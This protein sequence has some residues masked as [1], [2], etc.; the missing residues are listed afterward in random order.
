M[1]KLHIWSIL[2]C[3]HTHTHICTDTHAHTYTHIHICTDTHTHAYTHTNA[4]THAY[5]H[6]RTHTHTHAHTYAQ[7]QREISQRYIIWE[8]VKGSFGL[9]KHLP[10]PRWLDPSSS[11]ECEQS[12]YSSA[13]QCIETCWCIEWNGI[14]LGI[15]TPFLIS[16][17]ALSVVCLH[18]AS[19]V[20]RSE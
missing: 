1:R 19:L 5:T 11:I 2:P 15:A 13:Q 3:A 10:A 20:S 6:T 17:F 8:P 12:C 9:A 18:C 16:V 7:T 4:Y 14:A